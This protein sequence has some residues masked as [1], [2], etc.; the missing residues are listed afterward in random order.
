MDDNEDPDVED[1][2]NAVCV[3]CEGAGEIGVRQDYWG[4][5]E[6]EQCRDCNGTGDAPE[7][8]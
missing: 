1:I 8:S 7:T 3:T 5:W 2:D 4:N 6:T